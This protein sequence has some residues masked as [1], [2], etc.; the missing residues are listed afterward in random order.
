VIADEEGQQ[1]HQHQRPD[2]CLV[3]VKHTQDHRSRSSGGVQQMPAGQFPGLAIHLA[4][5]LAKGDDRPREGDRTDEDAQEHLNPQD[6]DF[7]GRFVGQDG[8]KALQRFACRNIH[9]QNAAQFDIGI[10]ADEDGGQTDKAVQRRHKLRHFRHLDAH[11]DD[12]A[13]DGADQQHQGDQPEMRHAGAEYGG[14][15]GQRH[16]GNAV[17]YGPFGA[18]LARQPAQRQD[19]EN[20]RSDVGGPDDTDAHGPILTTSGTWRASGV[21]PGSHRRC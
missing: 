2:A 5:Q 11:G 1:R 21:S 18:F 7:D 4:G 9:A 17:P 14:P 13:Q 15:Y 16:A 3:E 6:R 10:E 19:K 8:G 12:P 20:C